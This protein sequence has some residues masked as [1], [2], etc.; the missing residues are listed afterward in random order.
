MTGI[1]TVSLHIVF[2]LPRRYAEKWVFRYPVPGGFSSSTNT[3]KPQQSWQ[4]TLQIYICDLLVV[5][6]NFKDS[7][8]LRNNIFHKTQVEQKWKNTCK[9]ISNIIESISSFYF[10][11]VASANLK[12]VKTDEELI[13]Y[14]YSTY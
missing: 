9:D 10:V 3:P 14:F 8:I 5:T 4:N 7:Q 1:V 11:A 13:G 2:A 6:S 12:V